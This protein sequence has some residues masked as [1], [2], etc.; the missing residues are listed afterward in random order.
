L[1]NP[2]KTP[3]FMSDQT[4]FNYGQIIWEANFRN[5]PKTHWSKKLT[6]WKSVRL[7]S[8]SQCDTLMHEADGSRHLNFNNNMS[9]AAVFFDIE[10]T[11]HDTMAYIIYIVRIKTV[12]KSH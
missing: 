8:R 4:F 9:T 2:A 7:S 6:K 3:K 12:G 10:K 5:S 11:Q 1:Q